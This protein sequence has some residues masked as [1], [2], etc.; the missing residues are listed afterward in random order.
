MILLVQADGSFPNLALMRVA[1]HH[2]S[3]GDEVRLTTIWKDACSS[4]HRPDR[5]YVSAILKE[6]MGDVLEIQKQRPDAIVGG[7]GVDLST[8]LDSVG[9]TTRDKDYSVYPETK[10]SIGY[11][12]RGCRYKCEFCV[13]PQAEGKP[14]DEDRPWTIWRGKPHPKKLMLLDN[15]FFGGPNWKTNALEIIDGRFKVCLCQG[16][17]L[18]TITEEQAEMLSLMNMRNTKF[19]A[20]RIYTA[21]D[22]PKDGSRFFTGLERLLV[23]HVR[24]D[25]VMVYMLVGRSPA[26]TIADALARRDALRAKGVRPYPMPYRRTKEWIGFQRWIIGAYDKGILWQEWVDAGYQPSNLRRQFNAQLALFGGSR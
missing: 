16:V 9:I 7:S 18:R 1:A 17:N 10:Y 13:V 23:H 14:T 22:D 26:D 15:D 8:T 21:W 5:V 19:T 25:D 3:L 24:P 6:S 20:K 2:R 11:T 4:L 12:Q